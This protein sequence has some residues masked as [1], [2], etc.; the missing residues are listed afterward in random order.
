MQVISFYLI[1]FHKSINLKSEATGSKTN[2]GN[3]VIVSL[4]LSVSVLMVNLRGG[5]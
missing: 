2:L 5:Q 4:S 1:N 3:F